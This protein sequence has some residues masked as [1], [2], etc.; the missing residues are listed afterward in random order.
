MN[1]AGRFC[2]YTKC[3]NLHSDRDGNGGGDGDG[4]GDGDGIRCNGGI[5]VKASP[6]TGVAHDWCQ[7]WNF[8]RTCHPL[9]RHHVHKEYK[10]ELNESYSGEYGEDR[11]GDGDGDG[12]GE[13]DGEGDGN[14]V[15][16]G[17]FDGYGGWRW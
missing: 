14:G 3:P 9:G 10:E 11:N 2:S 15:G 6:S 13:S 16:D 5:M 4:D 8:E 17:D 12:D 1:V 7:C